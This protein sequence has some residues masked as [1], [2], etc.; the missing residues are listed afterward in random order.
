MG[1]HEMS[2]GCPTTI[3]VAT[4]AHATASAQ[5][6]K[7]RLKKS[8]YVRIRGLAFRIIKKDKLSPKTA[9]GG[10]AT[11]PQTPPPPCPAATAHAGAQQPRRACRHAAGR[12]LNPL[13]D[14]HLPW[15]RGERPRC[16]GQPHRQPRDLKTLT[17]RLDRRPSGPQEAR[18]ARGSSAGTLANLP[19]RGSSPHSPLLSSSPR[20]ERGKGAAGEITGSDP[21]AAVPARLQ[22]ERG[23]PQAAAACRPQPRRPLRGRGRRQRRWRRT[24]PRRRRR[25][26]RCRAQ[27]PS[28]SRRCRRRRRW[29]R[30]RQ[31]RPRGQRGA[32]RRQSRRRGRRCRPAP[33]R[34][35]RRRGRARPRGLS[36]IHI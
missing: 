14:R 36:L 28:S 3:H 12:Q 6:P 16:T 30:Q 24:W 5:Q 21:G 13:P 7:N 4:S 19:V 31:R 27:R 25:W 29:S 8:S 15:Q 1:G 11:L 23:V 35:A 33:R 18:P 2:G 17:Q 32:R 26:R 22:G 10:R 9:A 20:I 34:W